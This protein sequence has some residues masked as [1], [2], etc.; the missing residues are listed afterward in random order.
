[1]DNFAIIYGKDSNRHLLTDAAVEL[2]W[3]SAR[4]EI[5]RS[6]TVRLRNASDF[7]VAG[8]LMCF[9][10]QVK[11]VGVLHH[12]NQFFHGP[13]IKYEQN[14]FTDEWEVEAREISWYLAKNKGV[15]PYLKGES[16]AEL[17]RYIKTTGI[18]FR[19]P[20]L[21]FNIDERYGTMFHSEVILDVLQKAYERSGYRYHVDVVRTDTSFY[22]QVVREGTNTLVPVFI[23]EQMEAS[24]A[25]YSIEDTY[26][27]V[28]VQKYKDDKLSSS[29][30]KTAAGAVKA[31]GRMEEILEAEEDEDPATVATQRLKSLSVAKQIKKITVKH[32][33]HTLSGLRAGWMVLIKTDHT[34]KWIVESAESSFK[35]GMYT[36]KLELERRQ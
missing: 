28:T 8:M 12:K 29:V 24:T 18:D 36:V 3:S 25:G 2:S 17:Q 13:I 22:L 26:T 14:E 10:Q 30:T 16:G 7:K 20:K 33:D 34:S 9:S 5:A 19:C 15:R 4:D 21:G 6:A 31:M 27:V 11:G 32:E 35:N 1:M 23:P